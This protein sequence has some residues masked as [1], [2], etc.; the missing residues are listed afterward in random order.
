MPARK[1]RL[2]FGPAGIPLS[3]SEPST[4]AGIRRVRELGL[5]C[6]EVEFVQGVRMKEEQALRV[7]EI[8][9]EL[10]VSLSAHAPYF[11]NLNA[12]EEDKIRASK[13]RLLQ[14]ARISALFGGT[15][16]VFHPAYY[17][18][19]PPEEALERVRENLAEV[20]ARIRAEGLKILLAPETT[21]KTT[22]L[23]T[24]EEV[25]KLCKGMEG[26][27]PCIDFAHIHARTGRYNSYEEFLEILDLVA[28]TLGKKALSNLHIHVSGIE[29]GKGGEKRHLNLR[30]SDFRYEDL[31]RA[32]K[33]RKVGG[34]VISESPNR[35][36]DALLLK[37]VYE[38][39]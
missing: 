26:V 19:L 30:E 20:A 32:L 10:K 27:V 5:D 2:L 29:G 13:E 23:G 11:I 36:E 7:G 8:A 3:A 21:G 15:V 28:E 4:E 16:V 6:M 17:L 33:E 35:E 14:A 1:P 39:L 38:R 24:L 37:E 18:D 25:L 9:R 12:K 31:M 22:Q 34:L